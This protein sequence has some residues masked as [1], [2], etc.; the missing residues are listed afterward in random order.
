MTQ[1]LLKHA[2][3]VQLL[4]LFTFVSALFRYRKDPIYR[5]LVGILIIS[6][7]NEL[8]TYYLLIVGKS[9]AMFYSINVMLH[10]ALWLYL[11]SQIVRLKQLVLYVLS[12]YIAFSLI[13]L[14]MLQGLANFNTNTFILGALFYLILFI[15]DSFSRLKSEEL[16]FFTSSKYILLCAPLLLFITLSF[17]MGF[18]SRT[19]YDVKIFGDATLYQSIAHFANLIYYILINIYIFDKKKLEN[20]I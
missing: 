19:V 20:G 6:L 17:M 8:I 5:T 2:N 3:F 18:K 4:V 13:N 10:H 12:A 11:L 7:G 16:T 1:L 14:T 9:L 15:I